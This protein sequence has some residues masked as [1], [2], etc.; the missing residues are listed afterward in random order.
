MNGTTGSTI[1]GQCAPHKFED[2]SF[3]LEIN[4]LLA[5]EGAFSIQISKGCH[6]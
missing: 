3:I 4:L 1:L 2:L 5:L 6:S